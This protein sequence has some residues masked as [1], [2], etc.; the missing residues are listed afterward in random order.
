MGLILRRGLGVTPKEVVSRTGRH[1]R[2]RLGWNFAPRSGL[3]HGGGSPA[4]PGGSSWGS[5]RGERLWV[6]RSA[7]C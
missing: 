5:P 6:L 7:P 2:T 3:A 4:R 1:R